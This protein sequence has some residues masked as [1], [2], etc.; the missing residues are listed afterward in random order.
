MNKKYLKTNNG[1]IICLINIPSINTITIGLT[2][3]VGALTE[4]ED[5]YGIAHYLEHMMFTN[6][7]K[8]NEE[9]IMEEMDTL[10]ATYNAYTSYECTS[11]YVKGKSESQINLLELIFDI[12][13]NSIFLEKY[14]DRE[15]NVI[16]EELKSREIYPGTLNFK[17]AI[18]QI[19]TDRRKVPVIGTIESINSITLDKLEKFY[20]KYYSILRT[21]LI[22]S[23]NL[24]ETSI[25]DYVSKYFNTN[26]ENYNI[27][28]GLLNKKLELI[29][30]DNKKIVHYIESKV[31]QSIVTIFFP[32]CSNSSLWK[33]YFTVLS[34]ILSGL[35]TSLLNNSLRTKLGATYNVNSRIVSYKDTGYFNI[36]F[37]C[38]N[39]KLIESIKETI[40]ILSNLSLEL[41]PKKLLEK[42][43]A[44]IETGLLFE[45]ED[46]GIY[47][48]I[49]LDS[50]VYDLE[51]ITA[52]K[53]KK[54][55]NKINGDKLQKLCKKIF[56]K[57]NT[58]IVI[59]G[60]EDKTKEINELFN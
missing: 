38:N 29:P 43:K 30:Y 22:I 18:E 50:Y 52:E 19:Y 59:Q 4:N 2:V 55:I 24:N 58:L 3:K 14:I 27:N 26:I 41:V 23:G 6:T 32:A 44:S 39:N 45:Y 28:Y 8:R 11:Y 40:K 35:S 56:T 53:I 37:N 13:F 12:F 51:P 36:T 57:D 1:L 47:Y 9:Q 60:K 5:E 16:L 15:R 20:K 42:A 31:E 49:E 34:E 21:N 48:E 25:L 54:Y 46:L 10:G 33:Y 17:Y 7:K